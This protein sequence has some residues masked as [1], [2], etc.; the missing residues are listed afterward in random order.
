[1]FTRHPFGVG[2]QGTATLSRQYIDAQWLASNSGDR[3]SHNTI[4]SALVDQGVPGIILF[5]ILA[6]AVFRGLKTLKQFDRAGLL[7]E[8]GL[9][10]AMIGG[11]IVLIFVAGMFTQFLKAEVQFWN[12]ALFAVLYELVTRQSLSKEGP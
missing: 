3:A 2:H 6:F 8:Y 10:R 4:M 11:S 9:Y 12:L 5:T 1:M 7:Q